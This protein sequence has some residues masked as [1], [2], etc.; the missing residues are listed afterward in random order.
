M[1]TPTTEHG[2]VA[3][4]DITHPERHD[5]PFTVFCPKMHSFNLITCNTRLTAAEEHPQ[6]TS[7]HSRRGRVT[8]A[9]G[10]EEQS[11]L[12]QSAGWDGAA[13]TRGI[14]GQILGSQWEPAR[15][16][17]S[18]DLRLLHPGLTASDNCTWARKTL[19]SGKLGRVRGN[20]LHVF[21]NFS[22]SVTLCQN[23]K[24]PEEHARHRRMTKGQMAGG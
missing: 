16:E 23:E 12:S 22:V 20:I 24:F 7:P 6:N 15:S 10:T 2:D 17:R 11:F 21:C 3:H 18:Q 5:I 14:P 9:G 4:P 8:A 19:P 13:N 1:T